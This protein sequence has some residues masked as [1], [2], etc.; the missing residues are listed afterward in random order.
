MGGG[1]FHLAGALLAT[2]ALGLH[3]LRYVLAYG[4]DARAAL[5]HQGHDY[6]AFVTPSVGALL[7]LGVARLLAR[8][9][10]AAPGEAGGHRPL[11]RLW[12]AASAALLVVYGVQE[13]AEGALAVG[14]AEG[15]A[16]VLGHGG[17]LALPVAV[18]V[19]GL[20]A[21]ALRGADVAER[22]SPALGLRLP[23]PGGSPATAP[24]PGRTPTVRGSVLALHLAGRG[25]PAL[26][27]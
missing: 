23:R 22:R 9:V 3:E 8:R 21:L 2:G 17:W 26:S 5:E 12:P 7:A 27:A 4:G 19:G 15:I 20:V 10:A 16:G 25:P 1:R 14:H 11:R 24:A 6:L 13:L 18:A